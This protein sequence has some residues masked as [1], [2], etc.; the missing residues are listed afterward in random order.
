VN[1]VKCQFCTI[2]AADRSLDFLIL[3]FVIKQHVP[4][5]ASC[6]TPSLEQA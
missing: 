3:M 2:L 4:F 5:Y 1:F 6:I